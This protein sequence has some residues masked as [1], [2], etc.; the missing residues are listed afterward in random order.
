MNLQGELLTCVERFGNIVRFVLPGG[1]LLVVPVGG[2]RAAACLVGLHVKVRLRVQQGPVGR[3]QR[4]F[5]SAHVFDL[6]EGD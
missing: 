1:E 6:R 5:R 3:V 2:V 4:L